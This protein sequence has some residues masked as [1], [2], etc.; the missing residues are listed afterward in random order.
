MLNYTLYSK[1]LN[2]KTNFS[3]LFHLV[4][5]KE[6]QKGSRDKEESRKK[7][8]PFIIMDFAQ[9]EEVNVSLNV[10]PDR[11]EIPSLLFFIPIRYS[12]ASYVRKMHTK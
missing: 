3:Y 5:S 7:S 2:S 10:N 1:Q 6:N 9:R 8:F 12:L 11:D 4:W